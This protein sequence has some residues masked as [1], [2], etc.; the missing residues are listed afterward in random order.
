MPDP[1]E[2]KR[3][4]QILPEQVLT[5]GDS[6]G[7]RSLEELELLKKE[8]SDYWDVGACITRSGDGKR[9]DWTGT[10]QRM[11]AL[12]NQEASRACST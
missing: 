12:R 10:V 6:H 11:R 3:S 5:K 7:E 1:S 8:A 4:E 9:K 2:G